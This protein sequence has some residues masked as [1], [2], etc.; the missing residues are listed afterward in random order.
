MVAQVHSVPVESPAAACE[1]AVGAAHP[2]LLRHVVGY[3]GFRS[4]TR[5]PVAHRL[6]ALAYTTLV[7]DFDSPSGLVTGPRAEATAWGDSMWGHGVSVGLTPAGVA[8]LLGVPMGE[9]AGE[10]VPLADL[11]GA[12]ATELPG[13]LAAEPS[14]AAR[15]KLLDM[16]LGGVLGPGRAFWAADVPRATGPDR[17]VMVAWRRLQRTGA[18]RIGEVAAELGVSRRNLER[19]FRRDVGLSPGSVARISRFQR[20]AG[21]FGRGMALSAAAADSGYADQAH[22]TREVR[23][24]AGVTPTQLRSLFQHE[25][26]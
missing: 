12:R 18:P 25:P 7:I 16:L 15:Y 23:A 11:I 8:A 21:Q 19:G 22:L 9:L 2:R 6:L 17:A 26:L 10:T 13:R 5:E 24:L 3:A 4:G 1:V 20:V 14:W